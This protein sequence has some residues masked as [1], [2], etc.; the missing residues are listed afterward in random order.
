[1]LMKPY[2][3]FLDDFRTIHDA[4]RYTQDPDFQNLDWEVVT[5]YDEFTD[6][7]T[8]RHQEG[9]WPERIAFDHDLCPSHYSYLEGE[10]P[11]DRFLEKTGYH[12]AQ[13]LIEYCQAQNLPLPRFSCHS[14]NP[15]GKRNILTL[16][17]EYQKK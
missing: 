10:I 6:H 2:N 17:E 5:S 9:Y 8:R 15:T 7:I 3:L 11:Y 14:M 16:L 12:C 4:Y 1:M 13:W